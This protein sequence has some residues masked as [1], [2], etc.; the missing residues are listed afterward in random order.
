MKKL[1][2][3][4]VLQTADDASFLLN[5]LFASQLRAAITGGYACTL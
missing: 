5:P 1:K 2:A 4:Q 3:L